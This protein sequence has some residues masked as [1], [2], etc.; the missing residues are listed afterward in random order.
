MM[1]VWMQS[2]SKRK[3]ENN[4]PPLFDSFFPSEW[5]HSFCRFLQG[6]FA[7]P[8]CLAGSLEHLL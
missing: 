2:K 6:S 8:F 1:S 7:S 4:S 5:V 3:K